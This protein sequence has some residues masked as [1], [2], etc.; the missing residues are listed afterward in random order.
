[1]TNHS[2]FYSD[3]QESQ[4]ILGNFAQISGLDGDRLLE[5]LFFNWQ[6]TLGNLK[7]SYA[8]ATSHLID[9]IS[10]PVSQKIINDSLDNFVVK[11]VDMLHHLRLDIHDG[12]LRLYA[13]INIKG[14]FANVASNFELVHLQLDGH[15]QRL[16]L[17][18]ISDTDVLEL[19]TKSW[20]QA[21]LAKFALR[22]YHV[23]FR[24]DPLP[25]ILSQIEIKGVPFTEHKGSIV[26]L[27]L[28]RWLGKVDIIINTIKKIQIN[29]GILEREQLILKAAPNFS[30]ILSLGDPNTP[31]ITEK[32]NPKQASS[33]S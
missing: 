10:V 18:Q 17:R 6:Q 7:H 16:V 22:A 12:W 25:L 32:D 19:H 29:Q 8:N 3:T 2:H 9:E 14:I 27:E 26:Y 20:W 31:I 15:T 21:P 23:I 30:E 4:G 5:D 1:M 33:K 24:K 11:N 28:G 13:T